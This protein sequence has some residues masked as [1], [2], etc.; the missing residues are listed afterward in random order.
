MTSWRLPQI[1]F[2]LCILIATSSFA[3]I[4]Y[5]GWHK[6]LSAGQH[7]GYFVMRYE[8]DKK[9]NKFNYTSFLK[10]NSIGNDVT[11]ALKAE[12]LQVLNPQWIVPQKYQYTSTQGKNVTLIDASFVI[13]NP[14][15]EKS[16]TKK[17]AAKTEAAKPQLRM[18]A[19]ITKDGTAT[20]YDQVLPD[21]TFL[22]SYLTYIVLQSKEGLKV[23][24]NYKYQAIAEEEAKLYDGT[25]F[26]K[27][28]VKEGGQDGYKIVNEYKGIRFTSVV[29]V[30]GEPISTKSPLLSIATE[31][32]TSVEDATG[33]VKLDEK[34]I[35]T[36]F[37]N[38]PGVKK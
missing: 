21:S 26:V 8:R 27:E 37:G 11:E 24:N 19:T 31:A 6:V 5:E 3:D 34:N 9:T 30:K 1:C 16:K 25:A 2:T 36:L 33:T 17:K 7:V 32:A 12:S 13:E 14:K 20:K 10:T 4:L 28:S 15:P 22:S 29:N 23:G 18:L 38:I 35:R